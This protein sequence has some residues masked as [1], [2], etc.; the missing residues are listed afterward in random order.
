ME[1]T[2]DELNYRIGAQT[3]SPL[4]ILEALKLDDTLNPSSYGNQLINRLSQY[5]DIMDTDTDWT[6]LYNFLLKN[7]FVIETAAK[8]NQKKYIPKDA[9]EMFMF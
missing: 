1:L 7:K 3:L 9:Q 5:M 2:Q 4:A 8:W 6:E